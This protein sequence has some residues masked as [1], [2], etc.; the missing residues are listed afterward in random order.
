MASKLH[1]I[2]GDDEYLVTT[3][4][5][6]LVRSLC[7]P[8]DQALGMETV[9][10]AVDLVEE[11]RLSVESCI[12][13]VLTPGLFGGEKLVWFKDV[14]FL[15][16]N[17]TGRSEVV[18]A[19]VGRLADAIKSGLPEGI[20]LVVS[21]G[22]VN[23]R[24]AFYK[25]FKAQGDI[26]AYAMPD[27]AWQ[28]DKIAAEKLRDLA[29]ERGV[30]LPGPVAEVF[31][32]KAGHD[33]RQ[34]ASELEKLAAFI[35]TRKTATEDDVATIVSAAKQSL[36]WDLADA[37]GKRDLAGSL[38][39]LRQLM[40][41]KESAIGLV[42]AVEGRIRDLMVYKEAVARG[43]L[44]SSGRGGKSWGALP[45][46]VDAIF[47][48]EFERD[49]RAGHPFRIGILAEQ[50]GRFSR[51]DLRKCQ[52]SAIHAHEQLVSTRLPDSMTLELM[53]TNM[54]A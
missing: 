19:A 7:P 15:T 9:D 8:D 26:Q 12:G 27:K 40:F 11:A 1:L 31:L 48:A 32:E 14:R 3:A 13:A 23:K 42:M 6:K 25:A 17:P 51:A 35:G 41:Q 4:A 36:A 22:K 45:A 53:L 30:T 34:I 24:Y 21:A 29:A 47:S 28:A 49:P 44:V 37:F 52:S 2:C 54:L 5:R 43:W 38:A 18:K 33:T 39:I 50:A 16:D 46:E 20:T 10:G